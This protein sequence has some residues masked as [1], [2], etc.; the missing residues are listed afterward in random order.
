MN[1]PKWAVLILSFATVPAFAA[2]PASLFGTPKDAIEASCQ[3]AYEG[4]K[5]DFKEILEEAVDLMKGF[6]KDQV[7]AIGRLKDK[8]TPEELAAIR[9]KL[10][11]AE[12]IART[13]PDP[14]Q[15]EQLLRPVIKAAADV[16]GSK[17]GSAIKSFEDESCL[18]EYSFI[19]GCKDM[20]WTQSMSYDISPDQ[21]GKFGLHVYAS[22]THYKAKTTGDLHSSSGI[23]LLTGAVH[24][25][26]FYSSLNLPSLG[27]YVRAKAKGSICE[28]YLSKPYPTKAEI[29]A[30]AAARA[31]ASVSDRHEAA[32]ASAKLEAATPEAAAATGSAR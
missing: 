7:R 13:T 11:L 27:A 5:A 23:E 1:F 26:E 21:N 2:T 22:T 8:V 20:E 32:H 25:K 14:M 9:K 3:L 4:Y 18:I 24:G 28:D 19:R 17:L 29:A 12:V 10:A 15:R 16:I 31:A 6:H 30:K